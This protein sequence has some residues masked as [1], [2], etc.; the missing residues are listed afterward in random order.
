M[1]SGPEDAI[2]EYIHNLEM[3]LPDI[4][5]ESREIMKDLW[6]PSPFGRVVTDD[7][8]EISNLLDKGIG[9]LEILI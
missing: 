5:I 3:S 2:V 7:I 8:R 4:M 6:L 1:A 9:Y